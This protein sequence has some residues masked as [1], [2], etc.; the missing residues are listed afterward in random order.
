MYL[1]IIQSNFRLWTKTCVKWHDDTTTNS[2]CCNISLWTRF[3]FCWLINKHFSEWFLLI[4]S[5][6][7]TR[8]RSTN[9]FSRNLPTCFWLRRENPIMSSGQ[10]FFHPIAREMISFHF[11]VFLK[12]FDILSQCLLSSIAVKCISYSLVLVEQPLVVLQLQYFHL[13]NSMYPKINKIF[14][15][16]KLFLK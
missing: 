16:S 6:G 8:T 10:L 4:I 14:S 7:Q 3:F 5:K 1:H 9:V 15:N 12:R 11:N 2:L 13:S